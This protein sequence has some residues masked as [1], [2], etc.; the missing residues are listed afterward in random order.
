MVYQ[1][2]ECEEYEGLPTILA[3]VH[4]L[5]LA[6]LMLHQL[7]HPG[8]R[9]L[10]VLGPTL[11]PEQV[12]VRDSLSVHKAASIRQAL[13]ARG[14]TLLFLP[15]YS[16]DCTPIEQAYRLNSGEHQHPLAVLAVRKVSGVDHHRK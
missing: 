16:P 9:P 12:I 3:G 6:C 14:C 10:H 13:A 4:F 11:R 7:I 1:V 15:P 2:R 8:W 5:A